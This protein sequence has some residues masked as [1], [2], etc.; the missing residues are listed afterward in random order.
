MTE[1]PI[2]NVRPLIMHIDLNSCYAIIEQ[3]ANRLIRH[4]PV[5]VA[6]YT[7]PRGF[8]IASSYEAKRQGIKLMRV[9]DA[10]QIDP[11]IIILAPDPEKYFDAHRRFKAVLERYTD[12]VT[13]KSIDEFIVDFQGS[14]A[15]QGGQ[16]L[17]DVGYQ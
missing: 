9:M 7:T 8:I 6:A 1:L 13:P 12:L 15:V 14:R 2:N 10:Q 5:G 16:S 17:V 3:Q 11:R 4:K